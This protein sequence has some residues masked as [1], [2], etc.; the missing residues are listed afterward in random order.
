VFEFTVLQSPVKVS[1]TNMNII[2]KI[3]RQTKVN[4]RLAVLAIVL[5]VIVLKGLHI[6]DCYCRIIG[7][8][9]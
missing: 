9:G 3:L 5:G 6:R 1:L 2:K 4:G 8:V 7:T